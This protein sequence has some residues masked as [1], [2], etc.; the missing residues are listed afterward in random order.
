MRLTIHILSHAVAG[1]AAFWLLQLLVHLEQGG[2]GAVVTA[3]ACVAAVILGA[4]L[5]HLFHE[6]GHVRGALAGRSP[7]TLKPRPSPL[8]FDVDY[9]RVQPRQFLWLSWGGPAGNVLLAALLGSQLALGSL[10][11][12]SAWSAS[13]AMFAYVLVLE[14]P[15]SLGVLAGGQPMEVLAQHFGQGAPLFKRAGLAGLAVL[16]AALAL[17]A[18]S[19]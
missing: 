7:L 10:V 12:L 16:L 5:S 1:V 19:A 13:L 4:A 6:W 17:G 8:F 3:F 11:L 14:G 2:A 15:I 9:Q 18:L